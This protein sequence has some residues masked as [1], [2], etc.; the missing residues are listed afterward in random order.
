VI[1]NGNGHG[2]GHNGGGLEVP[3]A[4]AA[5][6]AEAMLPTET[7]AVATE[8]YNEIRAKRAKAIEARTLGFIGDPCPSCQQFKMVNNGTCQKCMSC[9]TTT[10]CS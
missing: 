7:V 8:V 1:V 4:V 6:A 3:A 10:G 5:S 2:N 9:G